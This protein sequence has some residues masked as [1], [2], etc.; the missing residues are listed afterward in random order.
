MKFLSISG[1]A[2]QMARF[3]VKTSIVFAGLCSAIS[4][5]AQAIDPQNYA[6]LSL[7]GD[8]LS[9]VVYTGATGTNNKPTRKE[10]IPSSTT[11][12]DD[13]AAHG[14]AEAIKQFQPDATEKLFST[15]A[16]ILYKLQGKI[17]DSGSDGDAARDVI[18]TV[19]KDSPVTR[20]IVITK[21]KSYAHLKMPTLNSYLGSGELEGIGYYVD[22]LKRV[23]AESGER[24]K[25]FLSS[26]AY[27]RATLLDAKTLEVIRD[28]VNVSSDP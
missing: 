23:R 4:A 20:L 9:L 25:G 21:Y 14:A 24:G 12:F 6:V 5:N 15:N 27:V 10:L 2:T 11:V 7:I 13:A 17:F 3:A 8:N 28:Q 26:F 18:R 1:A 16:P 22:D 19:L